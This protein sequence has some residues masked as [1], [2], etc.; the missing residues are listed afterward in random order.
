MVFDPAEDAAMFT[1]PADTASLPRQVRP[2][3]PRVE[4]GTVL[5]TWDAK[6]GPEFQTDRDELQTH[7][8]FQLARDGQVSGS[9]DNRRI[10]LRTRFSLA[11]G[12]CEEARGCADGDTREE[13]VAC[14]ASIAAS[15]LRLYQFDNLEGEQQPAE[16]Q[17]ARFVIEPDTWT[18][19]WAFV[20]F[21]A[22]TYSQWIADSDRAPVQVFDALSIDY[23]S[24]GGGLDWFWFEYNSSQSRTGGELRGWF[25][26][27]V[28]VQDMSDAAGLVAEG[29]EVER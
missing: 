5:F 14:A 18:R 26:N 29:A 3:Y 15:D 16:P 6:W 24:H 21:D 10:E 19:F 13:C 28:V 7:K 11:E 8:A 17:D 22:G 12:E 27:L 9:G 2:A 1:I 20:D 25:R 23:A 4:V